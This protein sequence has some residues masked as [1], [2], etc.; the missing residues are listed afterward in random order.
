MAKRR[1][2]LKYM[3]W[4]D[5]A[6]DE[7]YGVAEQIEELK[8]T[9]KFSQ[10]IRDGIRLICDLRQG[11]VEVLFE[12]FPWVRAEF[13]AG[14]QPSET[15]TERTISEQLKRL[16]TLMLQQG[17]MPIQLADHGGPKAM[18]VPQFDPPAFHEDDDDDD[19][20]VLKRDTTTNSAQNFINSMLNLQ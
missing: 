13:L 2:R 9:R 8:H 10:T 19:T 18:N 11:R 12:L 1:H 14:I 7:E 4:L 17:N 6:K 20:V 15:P 16:E 3:F 5:I